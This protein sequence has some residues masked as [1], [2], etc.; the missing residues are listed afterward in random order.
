ML[1]K[2]TT[3]EDFTVDTH[4]TILDLVLIQNS[5]I[6]RHIFTINLVF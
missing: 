6:R 1:M 4:P 5:H 2:L 3:G